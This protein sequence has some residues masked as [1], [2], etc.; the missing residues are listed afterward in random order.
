M[1]M[2]LNTVLAVLAAFVTLASVPVLASPCAAKTSPC[3]AKTKVNP[4][5]AKTSPCA[6]KTKVSPCAAKAASPAA[7]TTG[8]PLAK[9]L[10][11]KPA[12]VEV[13]ADWCPFCKAAAPTLSSLRDEYKGKVNFIDLDISNRSTSQKAEVQAQKL[14]LGSFYAENKSVPGSLA[15]INPATGE[16]V[17]KFRGNDNKAEYVEAINTV[18]AQSKK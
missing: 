9:E 13:Y 18:L 1:K 2:R 10:Q 5:A 6:A 7:A 11:G 16:I 14:G 12:I 3:A 4:C 15:I 17:Q 8:G